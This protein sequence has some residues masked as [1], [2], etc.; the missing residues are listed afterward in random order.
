MD[1]EQMSV[2]E[3]R[4][5]SVRRGLG[6]ARARADLIQRLTDRDA[7]PDSSA[8]DAPVD[9]AVPAPAPASAP[10]GPRAFRQD[11]EAE[12]GGPDEETHLAYRQATIRAATEAGH[13]PRGDARLAATVDGRWVYEVSVRQVT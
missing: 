10:A 9:E 4:A 1:Y 6:T 2:Q 7:A 13:T 11:F 3:L 8:G 5:E 12:P